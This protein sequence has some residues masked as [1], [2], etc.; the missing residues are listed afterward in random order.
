MPGKVGG[1]LVVQV[2]L[3][4]R[5]HDPSPDQVWKKGDRPLWHVHQRRP[6]L[7]LDCADV[8]KPDPERFY[9]ELTEAT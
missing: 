3:L 4:R 8:L 6:W 5:V 2:G 1:Q 7:G 9:P